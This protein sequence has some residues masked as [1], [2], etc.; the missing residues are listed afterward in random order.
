MNIRGFVPLAPKSLVPSC[1]ST[2]VAWFGGLVFKIPVLEF[3][4]PGTVT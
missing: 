4:L 1:V 2:Q 3:H